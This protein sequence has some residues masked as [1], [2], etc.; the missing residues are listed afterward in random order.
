[1]EVKKLSGTVVAHSS[2]AKMNT[3]LSPASALLS[4]L[5]GAD[6]EHTLATLLT[7]WFS[8]GVG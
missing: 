8:V 4:F 5:Q 6:A 7:R 1:M 2:S 3:S